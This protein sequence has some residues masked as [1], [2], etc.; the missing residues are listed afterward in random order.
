MPAFVRQSTGT[1]TSVA[2]S[3]ACAANNA[4][5]VRIAAYRSSGAWTVGD[6]VMES[7]M[8]RHSAEEL[9]LK[10]GDSVMVVVKSTEVMIQTP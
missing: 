7:V 1:S 5:V 10:Q 4:L 6:H 9:H 2:L 8:K 3:A